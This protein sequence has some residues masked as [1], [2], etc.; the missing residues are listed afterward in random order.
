MVENN[1]YKTQL[2]FKKIAQLQRYRSSIHQLQSIMKKLLLSLAILTSTVIAARPAQAQLAQSGQ[3]YVG[4]AVIFGSGQTS[5][6]IESRFGI[7][8]NLSLR[9]NIFFNNGTTFGTSI[10]YDL[11]GID[12]ERKLSP[13]AGLGIRFFGGNVNNTTTGYFIAGTDYNLSDSIALRGD[14]S[15]PFSSNGNTTVSL[16]AGL[17]F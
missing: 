11:P 2:C 5:V 16:G 13:F 14:V 17:R 12:S 7:S 1:L 8:E 9:P 15:I 3:N 6:G 4:P 10:T